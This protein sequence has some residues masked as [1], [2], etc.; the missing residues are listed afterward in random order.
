M[1]ADLLMRGD[2][3]L[4]LT[5]SGKE[6]ETLYPAFCRGNGAGLLALLRT[7]D[8]VDAQAGATLH[9]FRKAAREFAMQ[10]IRQDGEGENAPVQFSF[11][12]AL[13]SL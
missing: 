10:F 8:E 5:G 3:T 6:F 9:F 1:A 12:D 11:A 2:G 4:I 13:P 7:S